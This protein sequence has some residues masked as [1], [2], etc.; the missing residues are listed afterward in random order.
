[1]SINWADLAMIA[2]MVAAGCGVSAWLLL[3][4][5][6]R[7]S[8]KRNQEL[9]RQLGALDDAVRAVE[10]RLGEMHSSAV[11]RIAAEAEAEPMSESIEEQPLAGEP[12]AP[13][14]QA[15][16]AA[17]AVAVAGPGA[18]IRSLRSLDAHPGASAWSQQGRMIVQSSHNVRPERV[19]RGRGAPEREA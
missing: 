5:L 7:A 1:M 15:A 14:I 9:E 6:E 10:T 19:A 4:R 3:G 2:A 12:V 17:A 8:G 13:E 18:R 16:I 11:Q